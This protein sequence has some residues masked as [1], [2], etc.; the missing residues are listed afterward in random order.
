MAIKINWQDLLKRFINWQELVRVYK[1]GGQIR[2]ETVPPTPPFIPDWFHLWV[3]REW[4]SILSSMVYIWALSHADCIGAF[5]YLKIP[6]VWNID[7]STGNMTWIWGWATL[8]TPESW[9]HWEA[10]SYWIT[11]RTVSLPINWGYWII[12]RGSTAN[13]Y[14]IR[15]ISDTV[16]QP[17]ASWTTL[18]TSTT[19]SSG[20][21]YW[22]QQLWL[23]TIIYGDT[24]YTISDKNMWATIVYDYD[25][26]WVIYGN[27]NIL[28]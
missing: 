27:F 10:W 2:P 20:W 11:S 4:S 17:D 14:S 9:V 28:F 18:F 22:N 25:T 23:I 21:I 1:N 7:S 5:N 16:V 15:L 19:S 6:P 3:W 8:C 26:M 13:G 24:L 12:I